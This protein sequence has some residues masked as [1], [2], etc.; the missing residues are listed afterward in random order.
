GIK[1]MN[2]IESTVEGTLQSDGT[3]L[4]DS[5]PNLPPGRVTVML[6]QES[7]ATPPQ[8]DWFQFLLAARK[9][10]EEAGCHFMND[11]EAQAHIDWLRES[12]QIDELL[13]EAAAQRSTLEKP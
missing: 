11:E 10:M 5:K 2:A 1:S 3:L 6:R 8:E 4:L 13:R 12:D 9:R 7:N